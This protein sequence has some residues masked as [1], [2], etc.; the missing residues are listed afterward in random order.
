MNTWVKTAGVSAVVLSA[1]WW[2][3]PR[4]SDRT[5]GVVEISLMV[6]PLAG[7]LE[8]EV[9]EF[10]RLSAERHKADPSYPVYRIVSGQTAAANMIDDPTRF[11]VAV[12]GGVAPDVVFF[13]RYAVPQWASRGTFSKLD[14]FLAADRKRWAEWQAALAKDPTVPAPWPGAAPEKS[15]LPGVPDR[16]AVTPIAQSDF[17]APCWDE[18]TFTDPRTGAH[19]VYGVPST[20][21]NRVLL[22]N[23]DLLIRHGFTNAVGEAKPPATWEEL[24]T[25]AVKMTERDEKGGFK[26]MGFIPKHGDS[27]LYMYGWQAGGQFMTPDGKRCTL[28]H[29]RIEYALDWLTKL[30]D[31]LGGAENVETFEKSFQQGALDPFITGKVAMKIDGVWRMADLAFYGRDLNLGAAPPPIPASELAAGKKPISWVGGFAYAIPS[32]A[33]EKKGAWELIRFLASQRAHEIR[34]SYEQLN[35][36]SQ[37]RAFIPR[38]YPNRAQNEWGYNTYVVNNPALEPKF[39]AAMKVFNDLLPDSYYRPATPVGMKMWNAQRDAMEE[40]IR[41][42]RTPKDALDYHTAIVQRDLDQVLTPPPGKPITNWTWFIALYLGIL[43]LGSVLVYQYDTRT[44]AYQW[45]DRV[46]KKIRPGKSDTPPSVVEGKQGSFFRA[47]WRDGVLFALPVILGFM[48]FTG[49]PMLFSFIIS[50]CKYD[51]L[52]PTVFTGLANYT[53]MLTGDALFWKALWNTVFMVIGI[54]LGMGV[55]L[56]IALL[57]NCNVKGMPVWRTFFYLPSIVPA[58]A[59]CILWIWIF[60]PNNGLLNTL[61]GAAGIQGPN[62]LQDEA[63]SKGSLI[64]MGLWTAGGGMIVWLAGLKGISQSYY[65]AAAIDGANAWQ[66][67]R[68]ITLPLLT[69]YIFFNLI[70]GMI[71]TFQIFTQAFMMTNGGP[72]NSTLFFAYHLFNNAFRYLDMGYAAAMAWFLFVIVLALTGLQMRGSK[73]W[74]HYEG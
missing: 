73:K 29:P 1:L 60:N 64:L 70:M 8:E 44:G 27:W 69:P 23:K 65:E 16:A 28:N 33:R 25:M 22:Y 39:K 4:P 5:E 2:M 10:E 31:Q 7:S 13:D 54:P 38:Q 17:Y 46:V 36:L 56:G 20:A 42:K 74:V 49:G 32:T 62:W 67:F 68:N 48:L 21:D 51:S 12:A 11:L 18:A 63:T 59:S 15:G 3:Q 40:A 14:D 9:R 72:V 57:L 30:Y 47:Q 71:G 52:N 66:Q 26:S 37:G 6:G 45:L 50:F 53:F 35:S 58:V 41:K 61:L 43:A 19:G 55:G 24:E 34:M